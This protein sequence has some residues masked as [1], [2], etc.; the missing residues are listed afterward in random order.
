MKPKNRQKRLQVRRADFSRGSQASSRDEQ[1]S[2][3]ATGGYH[4]PGSN[5]K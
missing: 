1:G 2:R 4:R 3:W 5:N